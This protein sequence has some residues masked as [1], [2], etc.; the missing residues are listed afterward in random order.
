MSKSLTVFT[1]TE[2]N[3]GLVDPYLKHNKI[4]NRLPSAYP[5]AL[6]Q[7]VSEPPHS[8]CPVIAVLKSPQGCLPIALKMKSKI[9]NKAALLLC[10]PYCFICHSPLPSLLSPASATLT[11]LHLLE[12]QVLSH[13]RPSAHPI[14]HFSP[15]PLLSL[16]SKTPSLI[17][18]ILG[19]R[20]YSHHL[21]LHL[22]STMFNV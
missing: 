16:S 7:G 8:L 1:V 14:S 20:L 6:S 12:L 9:L 17:C 15:L 18:H 13:L 3:N 19:P 11:L 21:A 4:T 10:P 22:H 2:G 5:L